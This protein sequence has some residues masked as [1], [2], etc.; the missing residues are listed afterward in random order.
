MFVGY[1]W[2]SD[3]GCRVHPGSRCFFIWV[4]EVEQVELDLGPGRLY[5]DKVVSV[6][7]LDEDEGSCHAGMPVLDSSLLDSLPF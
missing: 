5:L 7:G 4:P 1:R 2:K 6:S 3:G